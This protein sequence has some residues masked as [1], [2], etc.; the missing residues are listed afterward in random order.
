M[1]LTSALAVGALAGLL[2]SCRD[3]YEGA[4]EAPPD[5]APS[6][7]LREHVLPDGPRIGWI[8]RVLVCPGGHDLVARIDTG[9]K[10]S[11]IHAPEYT[12]FDRDGKQWVRFSGLDRDG[13]RYTF[14]AEFVRMSKIKNRDGSHRERPVVKLGIVLADT[15]H[16]AEVNLEDRSA[17]NYRLLLGRRYLQQADAVVNPS[18]TFRTNPNPARVPSP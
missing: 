11:S 9:A 10:T 6:P 5:E 3:P 1:K 16:E 17:L 12:V 4:A 8:E 18:A 13:R 14:E 2:S 15:Y 7:F